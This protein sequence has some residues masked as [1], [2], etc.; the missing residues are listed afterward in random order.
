LSALADRVR[1][2]LQTANAA[3]ARKVGV[4]PDA[5][6]DLTA[7]DP[8]LAAA[9]RESIESPQSPTAVNRTVP[10][11]EQVLGGEWRGD[12]GAQ[13]FVV[14]SSCDPGSRHGREMVGEIGDRLASAES[15]AHLLT[16]FP[17]PPPFL[18]FDLET[19]G[20]GGGAGSYPFL[21]GVGWFEADGSFAMRQFVL[22]RFVDEA[23]L[24]RAVD[25]ELSRAGLLVSFNGRSFDAP[26]LET[27]FLYHRIAWNGAAAAH[28]DMLP[29]ARR[30]WKG[31]V[32]PADTLTCSLSALEPQLVGFERRGDVSG[33]EIPRQYFRFVRTGDARPL[34]R[35]LA[36]N[37]GDLL[38]L[39]ALTARALH[40]VRSGPSAAGN[41]REALALG[42][43][44][45]RAG[46]TEQA[47][48]AYQ[49]ATDS[50]VSSSIQAQAL[51]ALAVAARRARSHHEAAGYWSRLLGVAGCSD[52]VLREAAEALAVYHEHRIRDLEAART[53]ARRTVELGRT[54]RA[55]ESGNYRLK[56]IER[57]LTAYDVGRFNFEV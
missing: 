6:T 20:L 48:D 1:G 35:V 22:T 33:D 4:D 15:D 18:F 26:L 41:A 38:S 16:G 47:V 32:A 17:A 19:T 13:C 44:Y 53:F 52:V 12:R 34:T 29:I 56:R 24:L 40:L 2:V 51:K 7:D 49:R 27:R 43:I 3:A 50:A 8:D 9:C 54:A 30:F 23:A 37:R 42:W 11:V 57:K 5:T 10:G 36:H 46:L 31:G 55:H 28:L 39:A 14:D 21:V 25:G 45:R